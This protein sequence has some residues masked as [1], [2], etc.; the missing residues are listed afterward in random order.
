MPH[1]P[2]TQALQ[3]AWVTPKPGSAHMR[4]WLSAFA[5]TVNLKITSN[6]LLQGDYWVSAF[7]PSMVY[8]DSWKHVWSIC[9]F[10]SAASKSSDCCAV[11]FYAQTQRLNWELHRWEGHT[12][13]RSAQLPW[14]P[15]AQEASPWTRGGDS[16]Q[17]SMAKCFKKDSSLWLHC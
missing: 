10:I 16:Q 5:L 6:K 17:Q 14:P 15:A 13:V 1:P 12:G 7:F 3:R 4:G 9:F 2:I 8:V 11:A